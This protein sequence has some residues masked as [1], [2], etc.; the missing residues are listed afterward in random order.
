[1]ITYHFETVLLK[2]CWSFLLRLKKN[3]EKLCIVP[4]QLI[5]RHCALI[6]VAVCQRNVI[7]I[8]KSM[9]VYS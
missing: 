1:M 8:I 9:Y 7:E 3:C 2:N 4:A 5:L 6:T